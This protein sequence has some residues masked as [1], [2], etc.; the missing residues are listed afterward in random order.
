MM[1]NNKLLNAQT[2]IAVQRFIVR[3]RL[4][5]MFA[6]ALNQG[7]A[8]GSAFPW[9][10]V[11]SVWSGQ[12][13]YVQ[14]ASFESLVLSITKLCV[15]VCNSIDWIDYC[16]YWQLICVC[17][18]LKVRTVLWVSVSLSGHIL[19]LT[20]PGT[21]CIDCIIWV[22]GFKHHQTMWNLVD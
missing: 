4:I 13:Q 2:Y 15:T 19:S 16:L 3:F 9:A 11:Y 17:C 7:P 5:V 20:W 22:F 12:V 18:C 10:A 6:V 21:I 8:C 14:I 1:L